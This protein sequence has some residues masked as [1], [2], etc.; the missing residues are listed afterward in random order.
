MTFD[1]AVGEQAQSLTL[2]MRAIVAATA[3][4]EELARQVAYARLAGEIP[5]GRSLLPNS[6]TF[7]RGLLESLDASGRATFSV[8]ASGAAEA[9]IDHGAL[10]DRLAGLP[11]DEALAY[12]NTDLDLQAGSTPAIRITPDWFGRLPLL[13]PRIA[14]VGSSTAEASA[15]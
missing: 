12:L 13:A 7:E 6:L 14:V 1:H 11:L 3:V 5:R 8:T 15:P 10:R 2:T 9:A 4:D